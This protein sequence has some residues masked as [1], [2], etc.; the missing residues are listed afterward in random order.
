MT[1]Q[2]TPA[3]PKGRITEDRRPTIFYGLAMVERAATM[4]AERYR[5][6]ILGALRRPK[7]TQSIGFCGDRTRVVCILIGRPI[8]LLRELALHK[9]GRV[10]R[11]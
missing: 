5:A 11:F 6:L 3:A 9:K 10:V 7:H 2:H 8:M 4:T 1:I